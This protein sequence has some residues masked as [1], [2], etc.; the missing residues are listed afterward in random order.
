[1]VFFF[2]RLKVYG[3]SESNKYIGA[4]FPI[5]FGHFMFLCHI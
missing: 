1:M 5:A 3:N 2:Y 4:I